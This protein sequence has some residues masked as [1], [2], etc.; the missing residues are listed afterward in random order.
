[1]ISNQNNSTETMSVEPFQPATCE[2]IPHTCTELQ[3]AATCTAM[4][5]LQLAT[6][7][8][9]SVRVQ[10]PQDESE[11]FVTIICPNATH[12]HRAEKSA[13]KKPLPVKETGPKNPDT[14]I[15][16]TESVETV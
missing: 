10:H 4:Q 16:C 13:F 14:L 9:M 7:A 2:I 15:I 6:A 11:T 1:M 5:P 3:P 8:D 12:K